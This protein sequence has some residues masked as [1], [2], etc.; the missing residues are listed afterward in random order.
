MTGHGEKLNRKQD[1]AISA[2]LTEATVAAAAEKA[3]VSEASLGRWQKLPE[4][5]AAYL[6]AR[7]Q[8]VEKAYA[9]IQ[10]SSWA[11]SSTLIR[12]LG[13][14]SDSVRLRA[15]MELLNQANKGLETLDFAER[16]AALEERQAEQDGRS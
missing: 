7:R 4:F 5:R 13:S 3:G 14:N 10:Q 2:L 12:L 15:A 1:E 11:A 16:L 9:Q 6:E 8:V